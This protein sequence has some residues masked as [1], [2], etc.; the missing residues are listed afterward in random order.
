MVFPCRRRT[1]SQ[2]V[3]LGLFSTKDPNTQKE[4][5]KGQKN[6]TNQTKQQCKPFG[7]CWQNLTNLDVI[8]SRKIYC[9]P[10]EYGQA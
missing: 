9:T 2:G 1:F 6:S 10:I 7:S 8:Y 5:K 4:I 3:T